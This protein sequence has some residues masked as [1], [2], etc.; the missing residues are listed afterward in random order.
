MIALPFS[1][2]FPLN[3]KFGCPDVLTLYPTSVKVGA[4]A[5]GCTVETNGIVAVSSLGW[6]DP[7]TRCAFNDLGVIGNTDSSELSLIH[8]E[9]PSSVGRGR[10]KLESAGLLRCHERL[11]GYGFAG[12]SQRPAKP[13]KNLTEGTGFEPVSR[14][15]ARLA[16]YKSAPINRSGTP[17]SSSLIFYPSLERNV[18]VC[19][20]FGIDP[21]IESFPVFL[22]GLNLALFLKP[23][24]RRV[25][26][27]EWV[28]VFFDRKLFPFETKT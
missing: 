11:A 22:D 20:L 5:S 23:L 9:L 3:G 15:V 18:L 2:C 25:Y 10:G 12:C 28:F 6:D 16:D 4:T 1:L 27:G 17:R 19:F 7:L 8:G 13:V 14:V 21:L 24:Q 26:H